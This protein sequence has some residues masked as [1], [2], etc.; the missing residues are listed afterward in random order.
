MSED[1]KAALQEYYQ[2]RC[3]LIDEK[4]REIDICRAII[5]H[6]RRDRA[7]AR[8]LINAHYPPITQA[9]NER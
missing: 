5:D 9:K 3:D 2:S 6:A 4:E 8:Q 7:W 1:I